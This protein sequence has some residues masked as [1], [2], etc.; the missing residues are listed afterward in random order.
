MHINLK[1]L[2]AKGIIYVCMITVTEMQKK[3]GINGGKTME[4]K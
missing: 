2:I 3:D 1:H 4:E